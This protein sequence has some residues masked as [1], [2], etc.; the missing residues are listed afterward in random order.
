MS[1][2]I[3]FVENGNLRGDDWECFCLGHHGVG[4]R[5]RCAYVFNGTFPAKAEDE[6]DIAV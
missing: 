3:E 4:R 6:H 5:R 1:F 2:G